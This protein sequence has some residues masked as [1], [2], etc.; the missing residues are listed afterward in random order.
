MLKPPKSGETADV[1]ILFF[2]SKTDSS[3][4]GKVN[5]RVGCAGGITNQTINP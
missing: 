2:S 5:E 3:V 1:I 4:K